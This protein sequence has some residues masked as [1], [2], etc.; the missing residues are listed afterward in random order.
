MM[1]TLTI[2]MMTEVAANV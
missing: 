1:K 2:K